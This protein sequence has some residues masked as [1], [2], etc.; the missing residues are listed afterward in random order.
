MVES[1]DVLVPA[2]TP[3][4]AKR[5]LGCVPTILLFVVVVVVGLVV[6]TMLSG[7]DDEPAEERSELIGDGRLPDGGADRAWRVEVQVDETDDTCVFLYADDDQLTGSC[8]DTPQAATI[9]ASTVVFGIV[10]TAGDVALVLS[11]DTSLELQT[12]AVEGFDGRFYVEVVERE[13]EA[14]RLVAAAQG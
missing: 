9:G 5:G 8:D 12:F 4:P 14:V 11:D 7:D 10:E 2:S 13:V 6:G 3:R 1:D